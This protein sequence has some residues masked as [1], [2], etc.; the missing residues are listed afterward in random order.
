MQLR[1]NSGKYGYDTEL[2]ANL[3]NA[4]GMNSVVDQVLKLIKD[5]G[6]NEET[7]YASKKGNEIRRGIEKLMGVG[8]DGMYKVTT[9]K[10]IE[11]DADLAAAVNYLYKALPKSYQN[12]LRAKTAGEGGNPGTMDELSLLAQMVQR[13]V[14]FE[15]KVDYDKT[16]SAEH[17]S[18]SG[19]GS[20]STSTKTM[21]LGEAYQTG[22]G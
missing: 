22:S 2:I 1:E 13:N 4:V 17:A 3:Q 11:G 18:G 20:G 8:P 10:Q 5:F 6:S 7:G 9:K 16:A 12:A 19:S 21:Q 14:S 15:A